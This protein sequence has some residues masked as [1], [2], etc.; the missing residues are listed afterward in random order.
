[1][2]HPTPQSN[3]FILEAFD[4]DWWCPVLQALIPDL[5]PLRATLGAAADDDP[6]L[7]NVYQLDDRELSAIVATCRS[8]LLTGNTAAIARSTTRRKARSGGFRPA[9]CYRGRPED[10]A[11]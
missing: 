6:E 7:R 3:Q 5:D 9:S 2:T 1:M 11:A 8:I 4:R 10:P